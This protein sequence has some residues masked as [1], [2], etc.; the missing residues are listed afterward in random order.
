MKRW[1]RGKRKKRRDIN[2]KSKNKSSKLNKSLEKR[3]RPKITS[4]S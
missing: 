4:S 1:S 3:S 2:K